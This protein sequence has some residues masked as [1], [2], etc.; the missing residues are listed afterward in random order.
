MTEWQYVNGALRSVTS[1]GSYTI[2][3]D[4]TVRLT[5]AQSNLVGGATISS[6]LLFRSIVVTSAQ[7]GGSAGDGIAVVQ[8]DAAN[9]VI[10]DFVAQ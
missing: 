2:G 1:I 6:P 5:P 8:T 9:V 10:S 4:C 7:S 3:D